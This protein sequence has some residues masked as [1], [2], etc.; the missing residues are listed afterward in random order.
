[1]GRA[2]ARMRWAGAVRFA[3]AHL[4]DDKAVAKMGHPDLWKMEHPD[5]WEVGL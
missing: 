2:L 4:S 1:M 3:N 5:L